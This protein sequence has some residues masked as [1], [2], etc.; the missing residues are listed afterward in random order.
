MMTF[1]VSIKSEGYVKMFYVMLDK[2]RHYKEN[3]HFRIFHILHSYPSI[4]YSSDQCD[5]GIIKFQF[6]VTR[7]GRRKQIFLETGLKFVSR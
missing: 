4:I 1:H 3:R 7:R 2:M 6:S 5:L